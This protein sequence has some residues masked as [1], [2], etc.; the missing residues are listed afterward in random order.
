[1]TSTFTPIDKKKEPIKISYSAQ[2]WCGNTF[3]QLNN[4]KEFKINIHSYFESF[5]D[6]E[7]FLNKDILENDLWNKLRINPEN[8]P[9]GTQQ[10]IP[11]FEFLAMHRKDIKAYKASISLKRDKKLLK[12]TIEY[13]ELKRKLTITALNDFPYSI[14]KW[15]ETFFYKG[16]K[17]NTK[18]EKINTIKSAYWTKNGVTDTKERNLLGL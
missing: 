13:P 9:T 7:L 3:V 10:V 14:E 12:Y 18:A 8:L 17:H 11:S 6:K 4:K 16:K 1:M 2:E 15:E 5:T